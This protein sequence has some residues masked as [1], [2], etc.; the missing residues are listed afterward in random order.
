LA[1]SLREA[2]AGADYDRYHAAKHQHS[3]GDQ[4]YGHGAP[5]GYVVEKFASRVDETPDER[6]S[7]IRT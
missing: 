5:A 3:N 7:P 4:Q 6:M 2:G 1:G